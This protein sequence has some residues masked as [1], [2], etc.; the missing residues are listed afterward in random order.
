MI[1]RRNFRF[2]LTIQH[3][4]AAHFDIIEHRFHIQGFD[5]AP[6]RAA[7]L[8]GGFFYCRLWSSSLAGILLASVAALGHGSRNGT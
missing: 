1:T 7:K 8:P 4:P 6:R 3:P 2:F 5:L